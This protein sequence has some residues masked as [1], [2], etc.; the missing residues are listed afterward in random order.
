MIKDETKEGF[1]KKCRNCG[2]ENL[3]WNCISLNLGGVQDGRICMRETSGALVLGCE[4][5]SETLKIL[6]EGEAGKLVNRSLRKEALC[7]RMAEA[8]KAVEWIEW[9]YDDRCDTICAWCN[10]SQSRG[11]GHKAGCVRQKVLADYAKEGL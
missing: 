10:G 2:S 8:L 3:T 6:Y 4:E 5:C 7:E 1:G 9:E 11:E